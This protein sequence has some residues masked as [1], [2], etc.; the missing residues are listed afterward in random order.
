[1][2][3]LVP[4]LF[5]ERCLALHLSSNSSFVSYYFCNLK[6]WTLF[7]CAWISPM[8]TMYFQKVF[9]FNITSNA[10]TIF[11]NT[12]CRLWA[13]WCQE[14]C[15][16]C[17]IKHSVGCLLIDKLFLQLWNSENYFPNSFFSV[18]LGFSQCILISQTRTWVTRSNTKYAPKFNK[19]KQ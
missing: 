14:S 2:L 15:C 9:I 18:T 12:P 11:L 7:P 19:Q 13:S 10:G 6:N 4:N 3:S 5:L 17:N 1:M 16:G 8:H